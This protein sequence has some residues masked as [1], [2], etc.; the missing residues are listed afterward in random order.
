[1]NG[2]IF[3]YLRRTEIEYLIAVYTF[4]WDPNQVIE[5]IMTNHS[6]TN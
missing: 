6:R 3:V 5:S 2:N 1:M 4:L